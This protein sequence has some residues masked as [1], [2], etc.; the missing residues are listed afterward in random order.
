MEQSTLLPSTKGVQ[1][2][3][4]RS[5]LLASTWEKVETN[6]RGEVD[7]KSALVGIALE[8]TQCAQCGAGTELQAFVEEAGS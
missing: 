6:E 4:N 1:F 8:Q 7:V 5:S 3:Q 2:K